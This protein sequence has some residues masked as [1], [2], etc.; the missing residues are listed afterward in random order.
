M[1]SNDKRKGKWIQPRME[2]KGITAFEDQRA[3]TTDLLD[4]FIDIQTQLAAEAQNIHV[5]ATSR[6]LQSDVTLW[7]DEIHPTSEG[8]RRVV[9]EFLPILHAHL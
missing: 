2:A 6:P 7:H 5:L 1:D 4:R 9:N 3:I 8:Y